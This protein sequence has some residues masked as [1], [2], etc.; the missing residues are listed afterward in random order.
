MRWLTFRG[1]RS[2]PGVVAPAQAPA[3]HPGLDPELPTPVADEL[4]ERWEALV[5]EN[6]RLR[7]ALAARPALPARRSR[8]AVGAAVGRPGPSRRE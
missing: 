6:D 4:R 1:R 7:A 2:E 5:A 8:A 3:R